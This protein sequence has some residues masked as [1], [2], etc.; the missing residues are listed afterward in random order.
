MAVLLLGVAPSCGGSTGANPGNGGQ[1]DAGSDASNSS[2]PDAGT[3]DTGTSDASSADAGS[4]D[5]S[6]SAEA[7]SG[8]PAACGGL[9]C[10]DCNSPMPGYQICTTSQA[11]GGPMGAPTCAPTMPGTCNQN[12]GTY[13][14]DYSYVACLGGHC[15]YA[16]ITGGCADFTTCSDCSATA[17]MQTCATQSSAAACASCCETQQGA[18]DYAAA[19]YASCACG[20]SG[21]CH[22]VCASSVLCGGAGPETSACAQCIVGT[23]TG[24]G[25]CIGSPAFQSSCLQMNPACQEFSECMVTCS[26]LK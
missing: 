17:R 24:G 5:A 21:A 4:S 23:L 16:L 8:A 7:E 26:G 10:G 1:T 11:C 22:S 18:K 12:L 25:S 20:P 14:T 9:G 13:T 3:S 15:A 19:M 2:S 6:I